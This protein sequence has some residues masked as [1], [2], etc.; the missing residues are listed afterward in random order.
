MTLRV[1]PL[2]IYASEDLLEDAQFLV[3]CRTQVA[4]AEVGNKVTARSGDRVP[5]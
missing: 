2:S 3:L 4:M 5:A 1:M